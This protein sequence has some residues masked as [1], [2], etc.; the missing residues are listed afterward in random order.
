MNGVYESLA[1]K[2]DEPL[3]QHNPS[4]EEALDIEQAQVNCPRRK[5][6]AG[7]C[8]A[9]SNFKAQMF[10]FHLTYSMIRCISMH[11]LVS[12]TLLP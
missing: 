2:D 6:A 12:V 10:S 4:I 1:F 5:L 7:F 9:R 3:T 11:I 8:T